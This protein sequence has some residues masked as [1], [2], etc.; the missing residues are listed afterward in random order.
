MT[1]KTGQAKK[2]QNKQLGVKWSQGNHTSWKALA[3]VP[4]AS[5]PPIL[6]VVGVGAAEVEETTVSCWITRGPIRE[7]TALW[8]MALP[9]PKA[10]PVQSTNQRS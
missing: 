3:W 9:V 10:M 5:E 8:A 6:L 4:Q 2:E 7:S 1:P